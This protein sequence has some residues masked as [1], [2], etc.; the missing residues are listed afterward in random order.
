MATRTYDVEGPWDREDRFSSE[1]FQAIM[2]EEDDAVAK[3]FEVSDKATVEDPVGFILS[4]GV[5]DGKALYR[6]EKTKPLTL[7][8]IPY[9]DGY[10]IP[11]AHLRGLRMDEVRQQIEWR[12]RWNSLKEAK[13]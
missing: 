10:Q 2:K 12:D 1:N 6:V 11:D 5:A 3:L 8:H 4:F 9:G 7:A 13:S